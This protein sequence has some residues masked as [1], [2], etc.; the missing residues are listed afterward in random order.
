M[1]SATADT[2]LDNAASIKIAFVF[3]PDRQDERGDLGASQVLLTDKDNGQAGRGGEG[4][5]LREVPI[6]CDD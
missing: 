6:E 3:A 2:D 1:D 5:D 4:K